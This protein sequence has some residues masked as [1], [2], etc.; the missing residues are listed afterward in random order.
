LA[1]R[2]YRQ[3][4]G[5]LTADNPAQAISYYDQTAS[6]A[7]VVDAAD[8]VF[9]VFPLKSNVG[10]MS[11]YDLMTHRNPKGTKQ[12]PKASWQEFNLLP[13]MFAV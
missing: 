3:L 5:H 1:Y 4:A 2:L 7:F 8:G 11:D 6:V 9:I 12:I 10:A 13:L